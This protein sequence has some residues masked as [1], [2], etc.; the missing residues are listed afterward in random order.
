MHMDYDDHI[1]DK[2]RSKI[3]ALN[4]LTAVPVSRKRDNPNRRRREADATILQNDQR[5]VTT[6]F[7][8][9]CDDAANTTC[10]NPEL[11]MELLLNPNFEELSRQFPYFRNVYQTKRNVAGTTMFTPEFTMA[12]SRALL[13]TH[14]GLSISLSDQCE[15]DISSQSNEEVAAT[16]LSQ[17]F[18]FLC[19]PI[20]N[21]FYYVQWIVQTLLPL[22]I[23]LLYFDHNATE[24]IHPLENVNQNNNGYIH[25]LD[26]GTGATCIYPLLFSYFNKSNYSHRKNII[27]HGTDIDA[28]AVQLAQ[29][30]IR[31]N[32]L[33]SHVHVHLVPKSYRQHLQPASTLSPQQEYVGVITGSGSA[34]MIIDTDDVANKNSNR[35]TDSYRFST[36]PDYLGKDGG[37]LLQSLQCIMNTQQDQCTKNTVSPQQRFD[38]VMTNPPFYDTRYNDE[39]DCTD[40]H[41]MTLIT[42]NL[43][44]KV[45]QRKQNLKRRTTAMTTNEGFYPEGEVGFGLDLIADSWDLFVIHQQRPTQN[46]SPK[47]P[48]WMSMM[49]GKKSTFT[50][51]H[52]ALYQLLGPAHICTT[53]FGPGDHTRWFIAWTYLIPAVRSPLALMS[54]N[55]WSFTVSIPFD[56]HT[57][58]L[59]VC[60]LSVDSVCRNCQE[61]AYRLKE[62]CR[63]FPALNNGVACNLICEE[64]QASLNDISHNQPARRIH[65]RR[66]AS[67][68]QICEMESDSSTSSAWIG[69]ES[70]PECLQLRLVNTDP[71]IRCT[72]LLPCRS[73]HFLLDITLSV[74]SHT[75]MHENGNSDVLVQIDSYCH[76]LYGQKMI[77]K[78]KA[79]VQNEICRTSRRWRRIMKQKE[80]DI[81]TQT[82]MDETID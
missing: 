39:D 2:D 54:K 30:N 15:P 27:L 51:L 28:E 64:V 53:Q 67:K 22:R 45:R 11:F 61:I 36:S 47:L 7:D 82:L 3:D 43:P 48:V 32:R 33:D 38:F 21:R 79:Q 24:T 65:E 70:L 77:D 78:I 68:L 81:T 37:P 5:V 44:P 80:Q 16:S 72:N 1:N 12:L 19:P 56:N 34:E 29:T 69:D 18:R 23:N 71:R 6:N 62:Y 41:A 66:V 25:G 17:S 55:C 60:D 46:I 26:I 73:A 50:F 14:F 40:D 9:H 75:S 8:N 74:H 63:T 31:M 13:H 4:F 52:R 76:S 58:V 42:K 49:C 10:T 35:P 57:T 20:P 59:K